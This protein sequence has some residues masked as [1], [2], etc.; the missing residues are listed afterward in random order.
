MEGVNSGVFPFSPV[1][2]LNNM[3]MVR[4]QRTLVTGATGFVGQALCKTLVSQDWSVRRAVRG[5][6]APGDFVAGDIGLD[7]DWARAVEGMDCIV[8]LAARTHVLRDDAL[9]PL[10]AYRRI[11]VA[12]TVDLANAAVK[13]GV[14]RLVFLS[15]IKVNG[16]STPDFTFTESNTPQPTD[17]YGVS[18]LEAEQALRQIAQETSLEVVIVRSPLVY[19]PGVKANFLRLMHLCARMMPLPL[20]SIENRRSL[21]YLGNLVDAIVTCMA[22]PAAAGNTYLVSDR[23]SVSTPE[24]IRSISAALGTTPRMFAFPPSFLSLA[25]K[26]LGRHAEWDRLANS[27]VIDSLKIRHDLGWQPPFTMAQGLMATAQWY[28]SQFPLKSNT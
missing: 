8:H 16:E 9:D 28:H 15:S 1:T 11:N 19:G 12:A 5:N 7:T 26:L 21:I 14:R 23:E 6:A 18:K 3:N 17:A 13:Q 2:G 10:G 22:H 27:L 24:L 4:V 25:A 20:A